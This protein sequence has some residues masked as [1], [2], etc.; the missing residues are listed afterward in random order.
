VRR[1]VVL[2]VAAT[3][4]LVLLSF[5]VPLTVLLRTLA[6]DRAM[7]DASREAQGIAAL[8]AVTE[9]D[10]LEAA[11]TVVNQRGSRRVGVLLPS[12]Q[13]VGAADQGS[14][15]ELSLAK[16]GR[17]FTAS[18][19]HGR[20]VYVP[21]DTGAG[22]AVVWAFVPESLLHKGVAAATTVTI[23]LG[24]G[25]LLITVV[26][27][28]RLARGTVRPVRAMGATAL[29][30][31]HG[32][33]SARAPVE[34]PREVRE[35]GH[36]LNLLAQR[37]GELLNA[38]REVVADLSHRLRTPL[39]ALRLDLET[40]SD[41]ELRQRLA[42]DVNEVQRHL[43][44]LIHE[45]RRQVRT[46]VQVTC[47]AGEVVRERT[48]FWGVLFE[49]QERPL[50]VEVSAGPHLVRLSAEDLGA[51]VDALLQN[52]L[53]HTPGGAAVDVRVAQGADGRSVVTVADT[54]P[55]IPLEATARGHSTVGSTG[56]GLDIAR[57]TAEASGGRLVLGTRPGGG[58]EITLELGP[59]R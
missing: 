6:S 34:G 54:G 16:E 53:V 26:L 52:A 1:Q 57:R 32:D 8:V 39:T 42:D 33:L 11:V 50:T 14:A 19:P 10:Q 4:L 25:L 41:P 55:G 22:R 45:A 35:V 5:L 49:D 12:G 47:D 28:D 36:A 21:V 18:V 15:D 7:A 29:A 59:P 43:D 2:L 24:A 3:T 13:R 38:E 30:L 46:G 56:L 31:G 27:A 44:S 40:V 17:S 48:T 23:T 20:Q 37:I 58:A 9:P 51:A